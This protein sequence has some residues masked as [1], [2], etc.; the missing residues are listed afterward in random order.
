MRISIAAKIS[1]VMVLA[2]STACFI[3]LFLATKLYDVPFQQAVGQSIQ[4]LQVMVQDQNTGMQE[5]FAEEAK[6]LG[7]NAELANAVV[8]KDVAAVQKIGKNLMLLTK[9][10]FITVTDE[11]GKVVGRGHSG[12]V[13]DDVNNQE[14][15]AAARL[16][17]NTVG[18]VSGTEVPFTVRAGAPIMKDGKIVGTVGIGISLVHEKVVDSLK[19]STG[20]EVTIFKGDNRV[21][22]TIQENGKRIIGSKAT[23]KNILNVVLQEGKSIFTDTFI[24]GNPYKSAYW[25][26][27][28]VSG[29]PLGMWFIGSPLGQLMEVQNDAIIK[30]SMAGAIVVVVFGLLSILLGTALSKPVKQCTNFAVAVADGNMNATLDV[31]SNDEVGTLAKAL[32]EMLAHLKSRIIE[33]HEQSKEALAKG[34]EARAAMEEARTAQRAA[35]T[36][37]QEG[38]LAAAE[39]L[40]S[41]ASILSTASGALMTQIEYSEQGSSEQESR[42]GETASAMEE[43]NSTVMEVARNA[44]QASELTH[45]TR[46]KADSGAQIVHEVVQNIGQ[47]EKDALTMK[48]DMASLN[49]SVQAIHQIMNVISDIADQTN[50][51]ALNAA[52]EAARAGEAG[53]GFAVVADEVRKLAEKTMNSTTDVAKAIK[54]IQQSTHKSME[55]VDLTVVNIGKTTI[56]AAEAGDALRE[57]VDLVESAASQVQAIAAASEQQSATSEQINRSM[58]DINNI[59]VETS[60][61]M[62]QAALSVSELSNQSQ[63]LSKLID[64][65]KGN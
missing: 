65:M 53:R 61:S 12:K 45:S 38:M 14:T 59:A 33:S 25:P 21:M 43:M 20:M 31:R 1:G 30:A 9:S 57:I 10:D 13:G 23:D 24:Q 54:S 6:L 60:K 27:M 2:V 37:R 46:L 35:E 5:K 19:Q 50:L 7:D 8:R 51:L 62:R 47:V 44:N 26:I 11:M 3:S 64:E 17:K 42:V 18:I 32:H 55:Q 29:K 41:V 4:K 39:H 58:V 40:Q 28:S 36:A 15:V 56:K 63:V 16:G 48:Q 52:I 49:E 34:E 22:T